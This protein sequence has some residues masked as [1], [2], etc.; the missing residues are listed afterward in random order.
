MLG[1]Q[2]LIE[3][4][5]QAGKDLL[6]QYYE[7]E[8]N[9]KSDINEHLPVL[10]EYASKC[11]TVTELGV[12]WIVSTWAFLSSSAKK[13]TS[14]DIVNP[15]DWPAIGPT[16]NQTSVARNIAKCCDKDYEF[17]LGDSLEIDIEETDLLL[18]D[19]L[20]RYDQLKGE[21]DRHSDKVKKYLIFHDTMTYGQ[22]GENGGEG[23]LKAIYEFLQD[24]KNWEI[25]SFKTNNNGLCIL[26]KKNV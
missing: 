10:K 25:D 8:C 15:E 19:T 12:R 24:N 6:Q 2:E 13:I 21:L 14:I 3:S 22:T 16:S 18:L 7:S 9:F 4:E 20:H 17:I 26:K 23:I 1:K 11:E 5:I